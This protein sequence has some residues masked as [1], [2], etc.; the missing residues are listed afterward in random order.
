MKRLEHKVAHL[1]ADISAYPEWTAAQRQ[2]RAL[3]AT[4]PTRRH[5][6]VVGIRRPPE[7]MVVRFTPLEIIQLVTFQ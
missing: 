5:V 2:Q 6:A 4:R 7:H 1:P 3:A